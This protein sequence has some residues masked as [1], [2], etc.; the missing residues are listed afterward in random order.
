MGIEIQVFNVM[1]GTVVKNKISTKN[2]QPSIIF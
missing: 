1:M 2:T